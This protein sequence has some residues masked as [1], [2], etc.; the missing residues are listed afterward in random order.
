MSLPRFPL[1]TLPTPLHLL[2]RVSEDQ[3]VEV[4]IKRDDLTGLAL[5]G[6][7]GRK[8]EFLVADALKQGA[9]VVLTCGSSDSN[10][11]RM[12]GAGCAVARLRCVAVV[13]DLPWA[14][15]AGGPPASASATAWSPPT[16]ATTPTTTSRPSCSLASSTS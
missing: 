6:N 10:F 14:A 3:G 15:E 13:M 12:L 7:K 2:P 16:G 9:E 11:I 5:G 8:V 4:W 1:L